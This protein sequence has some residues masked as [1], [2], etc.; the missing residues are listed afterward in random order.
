MQ[1]VLVGNL[2]SYALAVS[3]KYCCHETL[4]NPCCANEITKDCGKG[5]WQTSNGS[6]PLDEP[7]GLRSHV[8]NQATLL[9]NLIR[10]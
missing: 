5:E 8:T 1:A 3:Q 7:A 4:R 9:H 2:T 6:L 10:V